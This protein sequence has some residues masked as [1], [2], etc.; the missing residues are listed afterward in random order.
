MFL[1][2][3]TPGCGMMDAIIFLVDGEP[4]PKQSTRFDGRGRA[5]TDPR[6]K[7]WQDKVTFVARSAMQDNPPIVGPVAVRLVFVLG[8]RRRVDLDNLAKCVSDALNGIVFKDDSQVVNLHLVKH[9]M[10]K[11]QAGVFVEVHPGVWLP[12]LTT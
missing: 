1:H 11:A 9:V 2:D 8:N 7:A 10:K 3:T 4:V 6:V 5:H 12:Y